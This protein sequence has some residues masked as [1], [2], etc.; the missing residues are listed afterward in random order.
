MTKPISL[1]LY[2]VREQ[3]KQDVEGTLKAL[4][5]MGFV[6]LEP[7][8][9]PEGYS[10]AQ[11]RKILNDLGMV[12]S[13]HQGG[14]PVGDDEQ[15]LCDEAEALGT[16]HIVCPWYDPK[17]FASMDGIRQ[18]ADVMNQAVDNCA[19]RGMTFGYHNHDFELQIVDGKPA[20]L[21]LSELTG[22]KMFNT[23]DTYWVQ[24]G[25]QNAVEIIKTLGP[26]ANLLHI[27]DGPLV[28]GEPMTAVG[29]GKMDFPP[30]VAAAEAAEWLV[31]E[32]DACATDMMQAVKD[33]ID[34]LSNAKL[35]QK[36][37]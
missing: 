35:G 32:L 8:G 26:C 4:G 17:L 3:M 10:A 18:V 15:R 19:K 37:L 28:K 1:Q 33:S 5:E 2:S 7:A 27:K 11:L 23:V 36:R 21:H 31:V 24:V 16:K 13:A 29:K 34:Y 22:G 9:L 25:G 14:T 6:G 30:I 12:V 20:L